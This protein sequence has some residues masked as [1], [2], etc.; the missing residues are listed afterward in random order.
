M[1][2]FHPLAALSRIGAFFRGYPLGVC[3]LIV[4]FKTFGF[5]QCHQFHQCFLERIG[6]QGLH[7]LTSVD[8]I[9]RF[10]VPPSA[11][12][13]S[14]MTWNWHEVHCA[15]RTPTLNSMPFQALPSSPP[16]AEHLLRSCQILP[17]P[18]GKEV[19]FLSILEPSPVSSA[20]FRRFLTERSSADTEANTQ[21]LFS[22]AT[23]L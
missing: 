21:H 22:L 6:S 7:P 18:G 11:R 4:F 12:A 23:H 16:M 10:P 1:L 13:P 14:M 9:C 15:R 17:G 8:F 3:L 19:I 20:T 5:L 2:A